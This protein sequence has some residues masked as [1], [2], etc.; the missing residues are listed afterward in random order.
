M[1]HRDPKRWQ[2]GRR[3]LLTGASALVGAHTLSACSTPSSSC[4]PAPGIEAAWASLPEG[5]LE[6]FDLPYRQDDP[7]WG[8]VVMWDRDLVIEAATSLGGASSQQAASLLREFPDGNT[9]ANEGCQLTCLAMA[10][11]L[12]APSSSVTW[13]PDVL[14]ALAQEFLYYSP[15]GL[16]LATLYGDLISDASEGRV[17]VALKDEYLPGVSPWPRVT[18]STSTLVRAYRRIPPNKRHRLVVMLKTGTYDDTVASH[19]CLLHPHDDGGPDDD[20]PLILDPAMPLARTSPWRLTDSAATITVDPD[21]AAAWQDQ[22]IGPTQLAGV[23]VIVAKRPD[24]VGH[25]LAPLLAAWA[26][27]LSRQAG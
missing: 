4:A 18:A 6:L 2:A 5:R 12:L 9:I 23:W 14:N 16:A 8:D 11:T 24:D 27:E 1:Q 13:T 25:P 7:R 15:S 19:F 17:Q 26:D 22:G 10:L 21:I 20:D 3:R